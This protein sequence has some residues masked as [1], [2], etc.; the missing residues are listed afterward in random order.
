M[1]N[2]LRKQSYLNYRD[3]VREGNS[4]SPSAG[5]DSSTTMIWGSVGGKLV[6]GGVTS[7]LVA[8]LFMWNDAVALD[9]ITMVLSL[10]S[11]VYVWTNG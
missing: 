10:V 8:A 2:W 4:A 6:C 9:V 1:S 11:I 5:D 3:S 7:A